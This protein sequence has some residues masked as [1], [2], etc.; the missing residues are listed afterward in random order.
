MEEVNRGEPVEK[1]KDLILKMRIL[2]HQIDD[3]MLDRFIN[4]TDKI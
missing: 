3:E 1:Q 2:K 4:F